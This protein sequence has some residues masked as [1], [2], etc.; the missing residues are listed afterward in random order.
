MFD[1]NKICLNQINIFLGVVSAILNN[2]PVW[3][4]FKGF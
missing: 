1:L 4:F 2:I 3:H